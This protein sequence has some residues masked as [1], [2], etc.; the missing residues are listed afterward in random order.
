MNSVP[1]QINVTRMESI[2]CYIK[3]HFLTFRADGVIYSKG[4]IISKGLLVSSNSPKKGT[5]K[6]IFTTTYNEFVHLFLGEFE[7]TKKSFQN[8]LTFT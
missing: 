8:Y 4:Q 3:K 1:G 7:D 2:F 6:F 5:N